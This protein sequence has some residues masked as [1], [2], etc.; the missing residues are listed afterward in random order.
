VLLDAPGEQAMLGCSAS[1]S[2][3]VRAIVAWPLVQVRKIA[4]GG[5]ETIVSLYTNQG[6]TMGS[7]ITADAGNTLPIEITYVNA[8][9]DVVG[10]FT[11]EPGESVDSTLSPSGGG[12][13]LEVL[14]GNV[15]LTF[16]GETHALN[17]G[18]SY[19][20]DAVPPAIDRIVPSAALLWPP[21]HQMVP[22]TLAVEAT[23]NSG[24]APVCAIS[25]VTSS[26]A[27]NGLGDGD[28]SP[29]WAVRAPLTVDLRA[30]RAG[31]GS[32]RVYTIA[33]ACTDEAGNVTS[34][35]ASVRV[36]KSQ[37]K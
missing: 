13:D 19:T 27:V 8:D 32:G 16:N 17:E 12:V 33:V 2:I 3:S 1:G 34:G 31:G 37:K 14:S 10:G 18:E 11:L 21:N 9:G 4:S 5:G 30:E 35:S 25:G 22:I 6:V 23:D 26:E 29:D 20:S 24:V 36:P 28:T 15:T 7:P